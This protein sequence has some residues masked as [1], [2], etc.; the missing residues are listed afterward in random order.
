MIRGIGTYH[1]LAWALLLLGAVA[2]MGLLPAVAVLAD[3]VGE[4][5]E[6]WAA[7]TDDVMWL[8]LGGTLGIA[9]ASL[10]IALAL[11]L[12]QA[13]MYVRADL[14]GAGWLA[15]LAPFPLFL[16]PLVH[17]LAWFGM[18]RVTGWWAVVMVYVISFT[19]LVVLMA[20]RAL[21]QVSRDHA[22]TAILY[23]GWWQVVREDV[24]QALPSG[25]AGCALALVF[26]LSDFAAADFLSAVGP[27]VTV[28]ADSLY[29]HHQAWRSSGAAAASLPGL[30]ICIMLLAWA[31]HRRRALGA[32]V[33]SHFE[34]ARPLPLGWARWPIFA[35]CALIVAMGTLAPVVLLLWQV[36]SMRVLAEQTM[37]AG[38]RIGFTLGTAGLAAGA[39]VVLGFGLSLLA[40]HRRRRWMLDLVIF[41]PLAVPAIL[42]GI[43]LIRVW[44]RAGLDWI[45]IGPA[46][47]V[48][49]LV[50][51]YLPFAYLPI[52]GAVER[53]DESLI[54]ASRLA[55]AGP[56]RR[57]WHVVLPLTWTTF[58][59]AWCVC[60]CFA[61]RELDVLIMLRAG[62][63]SLTFF[64]YS[65][66]IFARQDEVAALA[67]LLAAMIF[68]P[69]MLYVLLAR[70]VLRFI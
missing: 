31:L 4:P 32:S 18:L 43:G 65:N 5:A 33:D 3:V 20:M 38:P 45:Y 48:I 24:R 42:F 58:P 10:S 34:P 61:L 35:L 13:W 15:A 55:G 69:L 50:G 44:N 62:Q 8:R 54:E 66:V 27:K 59:A 1:R 39:M 47:V 37:R 67:L 46:M 28:Y 23:G 70:H 21:E 17:V 16:P 9:V 63:D 52:S 57:A 14:P 64:L 30:W 2:V 51:R 56:V 26:I 12:L 41:L 6:A 36:G 40:V 49:A 11:G 29:A 68:A 53:L 25:M 19:P 22:D 7:L 60:F